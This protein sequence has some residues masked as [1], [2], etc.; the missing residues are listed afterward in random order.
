MTV[1]TKKEFEKPRYYMVDNETY[2]HKYEEKLVMLESDDYYAFVMG[3]TISGLL[4]K[5]IWETGNT[6]R[7]LISRNPQNPE[8]MRILFEKE[9]I[10]DFCEQYVMEPEAV[11]AVLNKVSSPALIQHENGVLWIN[12]K[13][14][15]FRSDYICRKF[16]HLRLYAQFNDTDWENSDIPK[17]V[18]VPEDDDFVARCADMGV[19]ECAEWLDNQKG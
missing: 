4:A 8:I 15:H 2:D 9:E 17:P 16:Y 6:D 7:N 13:L 1:I 12:T 3:G 19:F 18:A 11:K 10:E 5:Y 14:Y